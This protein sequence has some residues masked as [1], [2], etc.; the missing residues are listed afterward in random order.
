MGNRNTNKPQKLKLKSPELRLFA[1]IEVIISISLDP[2]VGFRI[3]IHNNSLVTQAS[4][5]WLSVHE[6]VLL[7]TAFHSLAAKFINTCPNL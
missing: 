2:S 4:V 7:R 6:R 5:V 1:V 3:Y